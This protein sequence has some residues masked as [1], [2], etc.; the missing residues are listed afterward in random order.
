[1]KIKATY[2]FKKER[3]SNLKNCKIVRQIISINGPPP[4]FF[5][6]FFK[7]NGGILARNTT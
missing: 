5:T 2:D 7:S 1:M 4:S 3:P 6:F